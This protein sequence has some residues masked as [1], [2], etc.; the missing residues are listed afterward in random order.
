MIL[1]LRVKSPKTGLAATHCRLSPQL[2]YRLRYT[3]SV[4][5]CV[6]ASAGTSHTGEQN[7]T[8]VFLLP[9]VPLRCALP[10][11]ANEQERQR[12]EKQR[13]SY[14]HPE[15][16]C[17]YQHGV[18]DL[19]SSVPRPCYAGT[20]KPLGRTVENRIPQTC[21]CRKFGQKRLFSSTVH[22]VFSFPQEEKRMGGVFQIGKAY[23][24][25]ITPVRRTAPRC[26]CPLPLLQ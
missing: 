3:H 16:S 11:S 7:R 10:C 24:G 25:N 8:G 1:H 6:P 12:K 13:V 15:A 18:Q 22:G 20:D 4:Q 21:A 23:L 19:I 2:S 17:D 14:L 5:N 26:C 9:C